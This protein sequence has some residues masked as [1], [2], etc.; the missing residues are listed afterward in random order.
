MIDSDKDEVSGSNPLSPIKRVLKMSRRR[1]FWE[2]LY[3]PVFHRKIISSRI[4]NSKI[5]EKYL[6]HPDELYR[7]IAKEIIDEKK[8][9]PED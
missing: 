4:K 5:P 8:D 7:E 1:N 3:S 9:N 6:T 2:N